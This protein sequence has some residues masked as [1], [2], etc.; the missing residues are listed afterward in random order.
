M[1]TLIPP[2][3][4]GVVRP[5]GRFGRVFGF[6][7]TTRAILILLGGFLG[8]VPAFFHAGKPWPM[9]VWDAVVLVLV[10]FDLLL[11]PPPSAITVTRRFIHSPAIGQR[12]EIQLEV[13]HDARR[14]FDVFLTDDL[15]PSLAAAPLTAY[16]KAFP[17]EP[18]VETLNFTP[19]ER[20]D[21][22]LGRIYLRVRGALGLVERWAVVEMPQAVR[23]YPS[24][25]R[26]EEST[27]FYL[28]RAR[29]IELQKRRLRMRGMGRD[30]ESLRD[31][32]DSDDL[33][34][35]SW[36]A[37]ARRAKLIAREFV[38]ERS[39]QVWIVLDAGRLSQTAVELSN[40]PALPQS[41]IRPAVQEETLF[42]VTQLDQATN[43]AVMLAQVIGGSGDKFALLAYGR[44]IQQLLLPG[45]GPAH[46]RLFIDLLSSVR[47]E[48]AE[49]NHLQAASKLK[50]LQRRHGLVIWITEIAESANTPEILAALAQLERHHVVI[51][52][53]IRHPEL[54]ALAS[55][56]P[57]NAEEMYASAA[58]QEVLDRR[59]VQIVQLQQQGVLIVETTGAEAGA[60]AVSKYLEVKAKSLL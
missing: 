34:N 48:R 4:S 57:A 8:A 24:S 5:V 50:N 54:E 47:S 17:R 16:V 6:G 53:L 32:R 56:T 39:Q 59:R 37:T 45:G 44:S 15:H 40:R 38:A 43:A 49:A 13:L 9:F 7:L 51:L 23:V 36:T 46:L 19:R 25:V 14:P 1:Q 12:S 18:A 22:S 27:E 35:I 20:G 30:F 58:A 29:Q 28:I 41:A 31:Y 11:L 26:P 21:F 3:A 60:A 10:L 52:V 33:R 42:S 55:R 2:S